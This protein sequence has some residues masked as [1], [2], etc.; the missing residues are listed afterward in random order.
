M[1]KS[2]IVND[3]K[4]GLS[5]VD[6]L[7]VEN[8]QFEVLQNFY[9]NKDRRI[10]TRRGYKK[11]GALVPNTV[12]AI[13]TC[14]ATTDWSV[15]GDASTLTLDTTNEIRGAG[16][17]NFDISAYSGGTS[18]LTL[19]AGATVDISSEKG[20]LGFWVKFPT[21]YTANLSSVR[22]R[23]GS[24][25]SNFYEWTLTNPTANTATY[26]KLDYADATS[27]GTPVDTAVDFFELD[28]TTAAGYAGYTD[29]IID[30]IRS[31][32]ATTTN[33]VTS[34]FSFNSAKSDTILGNVLIATSG[35]NMFLYNETATAWEQ[36]ESGL[37]EF[38][39]G[40]TTN[41]T[42]WDFCVYQDVVYM[43][44]G[45][46]NYRKWDGKVMTDI[47]S[48]VGRYIAYMGDR[49]YAA[50]LDTA[51]N[52]LV[53]TGALPANADTL[54][55]SLVIGGD[56]EGRINGLKDFGNFILVLKD[57]KT[58]AFDAATPS[59]T[60]LD[61]Q[62]GGYSNRSMKNVENGLLYYSERG[63]DNLA[64]RGGTVGAQ[65]LASESYSSDVRKEL[66]KIVPAQYNANCALYAK[67]LT[68][69][70]YSF[71]T[72]ND[73][74]P[75]S[76]LVMSSLIGNAWSDYTYPA[77]YDYTTYTDSNGDRLN[78]MSSSNSGIV[79]QMETGFNDDTNDIEYELK[80]KKFDFGD[81]GQTKSCEWV[82]II[83]IKS[84]GF[85]I[86]VQVIT[87]DGSVLSEGFITDSNITSTIPVA[88]IGTTSIGT[89]SISGGASEDEISM[90]Q[91]K[92][93]LY[94][95]LTNFNSMQIRLYAKGKAIQFTLDHLKMSIEGLE[96]DM[97]SI[98][99]LI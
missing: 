89:E 36:I 59:I 76:T 63:I 97:F 85:D 77:L 23:I 55:S 64:Q 21:G 31:Y 57:G 70:Y 18:K 45:V 62:N 3:F 54:G 43:L 29:F 92:S 93:R 12:T 48:I 80:T 66:A 35:T 83:G 6:P 40:S 10:Q 9:Y 15:S 71:D 61:T 75:D 90:F 44:N 51:P 98:N 39:T 95:G 33:P 37:T 5:L 87:D 30:D 56:E 88:T 53:Y 4:G 69:Y 17:L 7:S 84:E 60:P 14:E 96:Q 24:D 20:Y 78:L 68:N 86:T 52:T 25:S 26:I 2:I 32:S 82:D 28:F 65:S 22:V 94:T 72:G 13:N 99:N 42:R 11:F 1:A 41:R 81:F 74:K 91:Y 19:A 8:N 58:Y 46:D 38:E 27:T 49:V 73:N 16:A 50:G 34:L 67:E 47:G 79:Y